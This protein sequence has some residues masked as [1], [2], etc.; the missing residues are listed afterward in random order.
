MSIQY[1]SILGELIDPLF[2]FI[3]SKDLNGKPRYKMA[4]LITLV[5]ANAGR[6]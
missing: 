4:N 6:D 3:L 1:K 2:V 5:V